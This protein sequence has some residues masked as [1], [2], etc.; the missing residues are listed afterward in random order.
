[1]TMPIDLV[2]VRHGQSEGNA[3][4]KQ[5]R[6]GDDSAFTKEFIARHGSQWRLTDLG[7]EQAK[8]AGE[9]IRDNIEIEFDRY[10]VSEYLRALETAGLLGLPNTNWF[11]E[12][13]LRERD[14]GQPD[15]QSRKDWLLRYRDELER[16]KRDG[17]FGWPFGGESMA[18]LCLRIDRILQTLHR[19]CS[20]KRVIIVCHGEV[21]WAFRFRLE[22]MTQNRYRELD[23]SKN[24][25][26]KIHNCQIIHYTRRDMDND[27][28]LLSSRLT[29]FRSICPTDLSLSHNE[30]QRMERRVWTNEDLLLEVEQIKRMVNNE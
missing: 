28:K 15:V 7:Q 22:R 23:A 20:K 6:R 16:H 9:W 11:R 21:M 3:A 10:Y 24:P 30:W 18:D 17:F 8:M 14:W 4:N 19:E 29:H 25:F 2:L 27:T 13:Y 12:I 1:M 5:F 26:D